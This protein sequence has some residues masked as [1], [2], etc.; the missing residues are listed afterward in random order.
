MS[1][2]MVTNGTMQSDHK[3]WLKSHAQWQQDIERWQAEHK[4]AVDR[5]GKMQNVIREHG[6]CLQE[7]ARTFREAQDAIAAHEREIAE[8]SSGT[9]NQPQDVV[10]NRHREQEG[11]FEKHKN[12]HERIRK[13]H[14][15][16]MSQIR[17]LESSA[18][19]AM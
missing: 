17:A 1:K 15:S 3:T 2:Q 12:A 10:A 7:H 13:H 18:A 4:S 19:A 5:L 8:Q 16:V 14:E 6:E 9:G 11:E